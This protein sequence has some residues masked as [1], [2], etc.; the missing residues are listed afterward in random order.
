MDEVFVLIYYVG[1][2]LNPDEQDLKIV[3]NVSLAVLLLAVQYD[4]DRRYI[5]TGLA[6]VSDSSSEYQLARTTLT[7]T[8][9]EKSKEDCSFYLKN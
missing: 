5:H 9:R 7:I 4:S 2:P 8:S 3:C 1:M 6:W